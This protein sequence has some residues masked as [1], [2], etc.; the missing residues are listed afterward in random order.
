MLQVHQLGSAVRRTLRVECSRCS[1]AAAVAHE[2]TDRI[3]GVHQ[4]RPDRRHARPRSSAVRAK[5]SAPSSNSGRS[6]A[7]RCSPVVTTQCPAPGAWAVLPAPSATGPAAR[8]GRGALRPRL[9]QGGAAAAREPADAAADVVER[10]ERPGRLVITIHSSCQENPHRR[11]LFVMTRDCPGPSRRH[12]RA[13]SGN[14][15]Q[16]P[17]PGLRVVPV[18]ALEAVREP[19]FS[20]CAASTSRAMASRILV[21][22]AKLDLRAARRA[23]A[24]KKC[25]PRPGS[26]AAGADADPGP[27][28]RRA[29]YGG[30]QEADTGCRQPRRAGVHSSIPAAPARR[31]AAR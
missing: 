28:H 2:Q 11:Q 30:G 22:I 12:R 16:C 7:R 10:R 4:R 3:I 5:T 14:E 23:R 29:L 1:G 17:Q 26:P 9:L 24:G 21:D 27:G 31:T 8:P 13:R 19:R 15:A 6:H 20:S 25:R 18:L